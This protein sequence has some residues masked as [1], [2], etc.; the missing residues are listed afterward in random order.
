MLQ[1]GAPP[2]FPDF[3]FKLWDSPG[4]ASGYYRS[5]LLAASQ[6]SVDSPIIHLCNPLLLCN[7]L[8][9]DQYSCP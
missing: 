4:P 6:F 5:A 3:S 8:S 9:S 7:L 2:P 1:L